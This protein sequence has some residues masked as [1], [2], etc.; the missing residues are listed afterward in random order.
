MNKALIYRKSAN[1]PASESSE[2]ENNRRQS[3]DQ[4]VVMKEDDRRYSGNDMLEEEETHEYDEYVYMPNS[5]SEA[6]KS[7][8]LFNNRDKRGS[9]SIDTLLIHDTSLSP[10][11]K[12]EESSNK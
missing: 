9:L 10:K 12:R 3:E 11:R 8:T 1:Q 6:G 2:F 4:E 5:P 7:P